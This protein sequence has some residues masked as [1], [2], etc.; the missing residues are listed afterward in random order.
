VYLFESK[1]LTFRIRYIAWF[2]FTFRGLYYR[3]NQYYV[4]F[5][6]TLRCLLELSDMKFTCSDNIVLL[7]RSYYITA[8]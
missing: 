3:L 1:S 2:P 8:W 6:V 4:I 7:I 5:S